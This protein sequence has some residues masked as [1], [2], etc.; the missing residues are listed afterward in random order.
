V[1]VEL[2]P[3][4]PCAHPVAC[5]V[6]EGADTMLTA[7]TGRAVVVGTDDDFA[8]AV[9]IDIDNNGIFIECAAGIGDGINEQFGRAIAIFFIDDTGTRP[10]VDVKF[11]FISVQDFRNA[12]AFKVK[13]G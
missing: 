5:G 1:I 13:K 8:A 12:V 9:V 2:I 7:Y 6:F 11:N 3:D 4:T 10:F